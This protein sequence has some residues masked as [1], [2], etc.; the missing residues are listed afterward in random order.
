MFLIVSV[1]GSNV[2][3]FI[4]EKYIYPLSI[5]EECIYP[6]VTITILSIIIKIL[7]IKLV[8]KRKWL[9]TILCTTTVYIISM[10]FGTTFRVFGVELITQN[11]VP[12]FASELEQVILIIMDWLLIWIIVTVVNSF[13]EVMCYL[14]YLVVVKFYE[15]RKKKIP[16]KE[17]IENQMKRVARGI[18]ISNATTVLLAIVYIGIG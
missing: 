9:E 15:T 14:T 11:T 2:I 18:V 4:I 12:K 6:S 10:M 13:I 5:V 1:F 3:W 16:F 7:I 8:A 17:L